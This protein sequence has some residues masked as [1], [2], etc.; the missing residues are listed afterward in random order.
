MS[1]PPFDTPPLIEVATGIA[2][3]PIRG[4]RWVTMV[5]FGA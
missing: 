5:F 4:L 2:F 1:I 3:S